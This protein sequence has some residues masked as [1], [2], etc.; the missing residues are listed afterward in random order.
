VKEIDDIAAGSF[1]ILDPPAIK[2]TGYVVKSLEAALWAFRK[3]NSFEEGCLAAVNL[4]DDAGT[5][6]AVY[7][8]IAGA[9]YGEE[10]IP[11]SWKK[12]LA[13]RSIIV[14]LAKR[15]SDL[16]REIPSE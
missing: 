8:Q 11:Q 4:G 7:G 9:F 3:T 5:T 16:S 12:K 10:A 2:G 13:H 15:L 6:G 14:S 1:K